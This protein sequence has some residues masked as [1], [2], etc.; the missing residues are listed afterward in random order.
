MKN[1]MECRKCR[2]FDGIGCRKNCVE[3]DADEIVKDCSYFD[4]KIYYF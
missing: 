4:Y 3:R 1:L 2:Y